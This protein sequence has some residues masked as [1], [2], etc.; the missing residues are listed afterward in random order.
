MQANHSE[1]MLR[2]WQGTA[3]DFHALDLETGRGVWWCDVAAPA[4]VL[5][6]TQQDS[7]I[8]RAAA[9]LL[10]LDVVARRSGGGAVFVH[11]TD[12]VWLDVTISRED[13]LWTDDVSTSMLWLG[14]VFVQALTPWIEAQTYRGAFTPGTD[15]RSVC[16]DSLAPG[17]VVS[18]GRKLVGISQRRGR[19][20]AR[21]Q[22]V[23][24][25]HWNTELWASAFSSHE[26]QHRVKSM[27]VATIDATAADIVQAVVAAMP[28]A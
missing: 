18:N 13:A 16:F 28:P 27:D 20:G 22:C 15:G 2:H 26:V 7:D 24:Y 9:E 5:G 6:S 8:D 11:P 3:R 10:G 1:W 19:F 4:I 21:M 12:S 25:R 14:D 17:E 23:L